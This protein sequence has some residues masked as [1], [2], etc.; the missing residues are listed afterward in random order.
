MASIRGDEESVFFYADNIYRLAQGNRFK[1]KKINQ[2]LYESAFN[3]YN[4]LKNK[5]HHA[6]FNQ[7]I[8]LYNGESSTSAK[9]FKEEAYQKLNKL[10]KESWKH[11]KYFNNLLPAYLAKYYFKSIDLYLKA[12]Q[13]FG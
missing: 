13:L 12:T 3:S 10:I 2:N 7:A 5:S 11:S 9:I 8:M 4:I 6:E 1:S